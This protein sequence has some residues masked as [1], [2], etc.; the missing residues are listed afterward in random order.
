MTVLAEDPFR[1]DHS[2]PIGQAER[3]S[4][5][6]RVVTAPN[7]G[8]MTFTGTRSYI[9]GDAEVA[10]I[11]PGPADPA[12][13]D[14]LAA[15][16]NGRKVVAVLVTHAHRDHSAGAQVF[17][18]RVGAPVLAHGDPA[19]ARSP[20]MAL[21]AATHDLGGGEGIDRD[22]LPDTLLRDGDI[23]RGTGWEL[24]AIHTPGHLADHLA[25][26]WEGSVFSGDIAM[27]WASTLISPPDGDLARFRQ[28]VDRL[29]ALAPR[30]LF[31]GHGAPVEDPDRLLRYLLAHRQDREAQILRALREGPAPVARLVGRLYADVDPRLHPAAGRNVFAHLVDLC[32]RDRVVPQGELGPETVF[33]LAR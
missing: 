16:V 15:A 1:R 31:P 11:D 20:V 12:H 4:D 13:L 32:E 22:F 23:V 8:P 24:R 30:Q 27:G 25:F 17:A 14:A 9:V 19:S 7:A 21:L 10:V 2:P 29:R 18:R 28:S 33:E 3:L 5:G 26:A 6:L